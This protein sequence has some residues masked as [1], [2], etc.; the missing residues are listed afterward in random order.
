MQDTLKG[1]SK[2]FNGY[3]PLRIIMDT[4]LKQKIIIF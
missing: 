4:I 2:D 1:L 3:L